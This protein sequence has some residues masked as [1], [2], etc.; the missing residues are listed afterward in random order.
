MKMEALPKGLA[1]SGAIEI[2]N[3]LKRISGGKVLD[4]A[5]GNGEFIDTLMHT[6]K[7]FDCFVGVDNSKKEVEAAKR[8]FEGPLVEIMEMN[9]EALKFEDGSFD[10]ACISHSLHHLCHIGRVL[11]EMKRVLKPGGHFIIQESFSDGNQTEAQR[12]EILQHHWDAEID[13]LHGTTHNRTL[14]KQKINDVVNDLKLRRVEVLESTRPVKCLFCE[15]QFDCENPKTE[16]F[17]AQS[18]KEIDDALKR[19]GNPRSFN[20][21]LRLK[22]QGKKL[23]ER[24]MRF[25]V[26]PASL[27]FIVGSK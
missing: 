23:R 27:L 1:A 8:R 24:A 4:V 9:G 25:G 22:Q 12:T 17:V 10:T 16:K 19:L 20:S 21:Q 2:S 6:L 11:T 26:S 3:T 5:T 13:T 18:I 14:T 15:D 7:D